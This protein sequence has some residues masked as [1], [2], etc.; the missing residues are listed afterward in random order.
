MKDLGLIDFFHFI[1]FE[2]FLLKSQD[3]SFMLL[4]KIEM[5]DEQ[6]DAVADDDANMEDNIE[7]EDDG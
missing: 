5:Q 3:N 7:Q 4:E 2:G 6:D 1:D